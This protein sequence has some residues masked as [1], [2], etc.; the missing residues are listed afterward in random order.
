LKNGIIAKGAKNR[1]DDEE[2]NK[3][4]IKNVNKKKRNEI[5]TKEKVN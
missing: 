2:E 3:N 4:K 1:R 5:D